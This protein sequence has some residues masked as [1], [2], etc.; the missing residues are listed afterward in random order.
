MPTRLSFVPATG[1]VYRTTPA[2][3][4]SWIRWDVPARMLPLTAAPILY[5]WVRG[6]PASEF[7]LTFSH[8]GRDLLLAVP[9]GLIAFAVAAGFHEYLARPTHKWFVPDAAD[10]L[11]QSTYYVVLNA[12][13]EEWFFRGFLQASLIRWWHSPAAGFLAATLIFGAYHFLGRWGWRQVAGATVAGFALGLLYLWQPGPPSLVLPTIVHA[14]ITC[15][16]LSLGPYLI[17]AYR[18]SRGRFTPHAEAATHVS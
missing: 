13:I 3:S 9:F 12:P 15:G 18:R 17:F 6:Q 2:N 7:G 8:A 10:L 16:F 11:V 4:W 1:T 5:L 14:A